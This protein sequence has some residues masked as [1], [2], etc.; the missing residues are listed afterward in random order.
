MTFPTV[1]SVANLLCPG[2]TAPV[3]PAYPSIAVA[4][5]HLKELPG[6]LFVMGSHA[7]RAEPR[8]VQLSPFAI[9]RTV[10]RADAFDPNT[11]R[12]KDRPA[13]NMKWSSARTFAEARGLRLPTEAEWEYTARGPAIN[14]QQ[15]LTEIMRQ[16]GIGFSPELLDRV[17]K[18]L[19]VENF[20]F[21]PLGQI[22]TDLK[23]GLFLGLVSQG[24]PFYGW[25]MYGTPSGQPT[26]E[27]AW[28]DRGETGPVDW[29]KES[30]YGT[31][32]MAGNVWEYMFDTYSPFPT[33]TLDPLD[34][35]P[36][37]PR[38]IRGGGTN[39]NASITNLLAAT[40]LDHPHAFG[41][42]DVGFRMAMGPGPEG[43]I[44]KQPDDAA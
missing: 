9:G 27:E 28:F 19:S 16:E 29:G 32:G 18:E 34:D 38:A 3:L 10:V 37:T 44:A 15:R 23:D 20:V 12:P 35:K 22:F 30:P 39:N 33:G 2:I 21:G 13:T 17:I 26:H 14:V 42:D 6:G 11:S 36:N 8:W 43:K 5:Y 4:G 1:T 31:L 40:R 7:H 24:L 25:R 41:S